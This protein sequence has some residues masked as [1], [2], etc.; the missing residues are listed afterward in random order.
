MAFA[1]LTVT[2]PRNR[3]VYL[4]GN[5]NDPAGNSS[6]DTFTVPSGGNIAETLNANR[7]VDFRKKF[8]VKATETAVSVALDPVNP[9][10]P[11]Q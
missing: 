6:T 7:E 9:P 3:I 8:R 1:S 2:F 11:T 5:Y 10:E 4:N